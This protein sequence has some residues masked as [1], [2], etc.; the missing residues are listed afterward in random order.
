[1][2]NK[3]R[4]VVAQQQLV[5]LLVINKSHL[6]QPRIQ[7]QNIKITKTINK[8]KLQNIEKPANM[9]TL[10]F[11]NSITKSDLRS[12]LEIISHVKIF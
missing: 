7:S 11:G 9:K 8:I 5:P 12:Q 10:C 2:L 3:Y 4:L 6:Q 1:V